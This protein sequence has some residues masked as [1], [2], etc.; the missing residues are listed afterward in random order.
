MNIA[1]YIIQQSRQWFNSD[2]VL[3]INITK[4]YK[5]TQICIELHHNWSKCSCNKDT[6][7]ELKGLLNLNNAY[8]NLVNVGCWHHGGNQLNPPIN[9]LYLGSFLILLFEYICLCENIYIIHVEN[10]T[11]SSIY[12]TLHYEYKCSML[13][14]EMFKSLTGFDAQLQWKKNWKS[15]IKKIKP[16]HIWRKLLPLS[17]YF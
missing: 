10:M 8:L 5:K 6:K 11:T 7:V 13:D 16:N 12:N 1:N 17:R 4:L 9:H 14:P 3:D 15:L 2:Y